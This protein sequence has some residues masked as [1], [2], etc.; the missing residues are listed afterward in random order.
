MI[1]KNEKNEYPILPLRN[2]VLF[3]QQIFP[4]YIGREQSLNLIDSLPKKGKKYIVV[5]AQKDGS[6]EN[7]KKSDLYE[8]GTLATVMKIFDM[9]D[10][11]KSAIVQGIERV[12]LIDIVKEKPFYSGKIDLSPKVKVEES[13]EFAPMIENLKQNYSK[14]IEIAPYL[15]GEQM[16][17]FSNLKDPGKLA[18][19]TISMMNVSTEEK[20]EVLEELDIL[21]RLEKSN[22]IITRE[23]QRIELS[24][25]NTNRCSR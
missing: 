7:P 10:N 23:I 15:S 6:V 1:E 4:V 19:R 20:Q 21:T 3:P 18:D 8:W 12:R 17:I 9:P 14:L 16:K 13:I 11:S 2:T 5:I 24:E 25:K 22:V